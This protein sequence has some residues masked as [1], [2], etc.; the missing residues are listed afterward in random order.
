LKEIDTLIADVLD[1]NAEPADR[2]GAFGEIVA[3]Y[4]NMTFA[5]AHAILKDYYLAE[6]AAQ[7]AFIVAWQKL[8]QI[9]EPKAFPGWLKKIVFSEC[10]R[11]TR[12][13][14]LLVMPLDN[15]LSIPSSSP[16]PQ[17]IAE[18][19]E[20]S[21]KV[22]AAIRALPDSER[23][24]TMLFYIDGY[25]H[26]DISDFLE[27]RVT[28]VAKRLFSARRRLK[29]GL[30]GMVKDDL[31][32]H[33]P[34]RHT[35][36]ADQIQARLRPVVEQDWQMVTS[37]AYGIDP[38]ISGN[39]DSWLRDRKRFDESRYIRRHYVAQHAETGQ[40][41]GYGAIEQTIFLPNYRLLLVVAPQHMRSGVG[42]LLLD[43]LMK[44]LQEVNAIAIWHRSD[45]RFA[46][47]LTFLKAHGFVETSLVRDLTLP[48]A[49]FDPT[50]FKP[51]TARGVSIVT[52]AEQRERDSECLRKLQEL[53]NSLMADVPGRQHFAPVPLDTVA[54]WFSRRSLPPDACFIAIDGDRY[55]GITSLILTGEE[56]ESIT[57]GFT[58]VIK[59]RRRQGIATALKL[60]AIQYARCQGYKSIRALN[61]HLNLPIMA[62]NERLGFHGCLSYMTL[63]KCLKEV[64]AIDSCVT[65]AYVGLYAFDSSH[66]EDH[67]LPANL[68]VRVKKA[69]TRLISEIR[70]MQDELFP[71]SE[72]RFFIK[73][74]YGEVEFARDEQGHVTG[75][76][77]RESG[78]EMCAAKIE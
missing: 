53:L 31:K 73:M 19:L 58:G 40:L 16:D 9:K 64:R 21:E 54:R 24:V 22:L 43:Q 66:L 61:E 3:R 45:T 41:L 50:P 47:T 67:K 7:E 75:L 27:L 29:Q 5:C 23:M 71:E 35:A 1:P 42:D 60:R 10:N 77:Y 56:K 30:I 17:A 38:G 37:I 32:Q 33:R 12:G 76:I 69:G 65:D 8:D 26:S 78:K 39:H 14:R 48:V 36:F 4:Q 57:Q 52:Y 51:K 15:E 6:D 72:S 70:D 68:T 18:K 11:L 55:I 46:D 28:T 34:S 2:H 13:K 63:E 20:L 49:D 25:S 62:L 74:H 59:E 44:D